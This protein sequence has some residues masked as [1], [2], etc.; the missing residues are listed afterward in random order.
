[1]VG[2]TIGGG[3]GRYQGL[4]GLIVDSLLS[5]RLVTA[6]GMLIDV[7][8]TS[9]PD[10]FWAIRGAG[11]NFGII[12]SATYRL[13]PLTNDGLVMNAD[14]IFPASSNASYF[15]IIQSLQDT[16]PA[17]LATISIMEYNGTSDEVSQ[18]CFNQRLTT[19]AHIHHRR[20]FSQTGFI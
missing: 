15:D 4:N 19:C 9:N 14:F 18:C 20:K 2:A 17:E 3:V 10:L 16:I 5:V 12:T 11:A 13:Y 1:M 6:E 8:N 7:S